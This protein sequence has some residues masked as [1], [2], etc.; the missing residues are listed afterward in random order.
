MQ[1]GTGRRSSLGLLYICVCA[2]LWCG[3]PLSS[4]AVDT[5]MFATYDALAAR[6]AR[7]HASAPQQ[8]VTHTP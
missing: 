3:E 5:H 7:R 8:Q 6:I 1:M 4:A 2:H